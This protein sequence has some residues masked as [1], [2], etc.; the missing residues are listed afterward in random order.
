[1]ETVRLS[2]KGQ[3]VIPKGMRDDMHLPPGT[4]FIIS[5]TATGFTLTPVTLFPKTEVNEVRGSLARKNRRLPSDAEVKSRIKERLKLQ[6]L[7]I[8]GKSK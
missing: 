5:V 7:A 4:E 3:I 2:S 8:K 1:M 6:D